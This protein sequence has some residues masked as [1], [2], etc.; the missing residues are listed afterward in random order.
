MPISRVP[1]YP[2]Y[3]VW[4]PA[5]RR[6]SESGILPVLSKLGISVYVNQSLLEHEDDA[7]IWR[8][9]IISRVIQQFWEDVLWGKLDYLIVDLPPALRTLAD[10]FA[11]HPGIGRRNRIQPAGTGMPWWLRKPSEWRGNWIYLYWVSWKI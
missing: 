5:G 6:S 4:V 9:P 8:G 1:A 7:V 10:R 2:R 3:S 11:N